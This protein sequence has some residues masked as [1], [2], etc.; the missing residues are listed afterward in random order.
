MNTYCVNI[1]LLRSTSTMVAWNDKKHFGLIIIAWK[2]FIWW[3]QLK[4]LKSELTHYSDETWK[5]HWVCRWKAS[6]AVKNFRCG[7]FYNNRAHIEKL[8]LGNEPDIGL[9]VVS[10]KLQEPL[11]KE[12]KSLIC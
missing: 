6:P 1:V 11:E 9:S 4:L 3:K 10:F 7:L 8:I 5:D 2:C 12:W